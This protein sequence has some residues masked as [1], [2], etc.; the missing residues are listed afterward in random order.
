MVRRHLCARARAC[1]RLCG[2]A[3][4]RLC[5]YS[6]VRLHAFAL[7]RLRVCVALSTFAF[8]CVCALARLGASALAYL[9]LLLTILFCGLAKT[10]GAEQAE[11]QANAAGKVIVQKKFESIGLQFEEVLTAPRLECCN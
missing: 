9:R 4:A 10:R 8:L 2:Y 1:V 7:L 3:L 5:E 11:C 6:F